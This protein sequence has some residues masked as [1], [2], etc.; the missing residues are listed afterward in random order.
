MSMNRRP[1]AARTRRQGK[2]RLAGRNRWTRSLEMLERRELL[3][4]DTGVSTPWHNA[5]N[6]LDVN[7]DN[8]VTPL[9]ALIVFNDLLR[10]GMRPVPLD[11]VAPLTNGGGAAAPVKYVDVTGDNIVTPLDALRIVNALAVDDQAQIKVVATDLF[12]TQITET[13]VGSQFQLRAI[14]Q[15]VRTPPAQFGGVFAAYLNVSYDSSLATIPTVG[16]QFEFDPFFSAVQT[17]DTGTPGLISGAGASSTSG[18]PPGTAPQPLWS[19]LVTASAAGV[20][21]FTP[22]FDSTLGHGV[23]LYSLDEDVPSNAIDFVGTT[24]TITAE[25]SI[26][27][28]NVTL[29]EGNSGTTPFVFNVSLSNVHNQPVTVQYATANPP[30]GNI[31]TPG[32]D[33]TATSG[34]LTFAPGT[35]LRAVTVLVNGDLAV[36]SDEVF[37]LVLSNPTNATLGTASTGIGTILN[38]DALSNLTIGDVTVQNVTAGTTNAVFTVTLSPAAASTATVQFATANGTA[39]AGVDYTST[40]GTLTFA[41]GVTTRTITVPVIG[42]PL[43]DTTETFFINLT[44]PSANALITDSQAQGTIL[45]AVAI[46]NLAIS[47]AA[48]NEGNVGTTDMVFTVSLSTPA[49]EQILVAYATADGTATVADDDYVATSGTLTFAPGESV[50]LIT[51]P[52]IGDTTLE[53]TETFTVNLTPVSGTLGTFQSQAT[54]TIN[55]DDGTPT[56]VIDNATVTGSPTSIVDAVFTVTLSVAITSQVTVSYATADGSAEANVDYLPQSG[57][58]TFTPG[59]SLTQTITVPVLPS[60]VAQADET[61]FVNLSSATGGAEI[62]DAQA[63][64]TIVRQG[65]T[66][67]D[68]S[69]LEGNSGTTDAVFTI[70]LTQAQQEVVTVQYSTA[71]GTATVAGADYVPTSGTV[72]FAPG[73]TAKTVTVAIVGDTTVEPN[74]TF[75]VN[76]SNAIG[77]AIFKETGIGTILNDDGQKALIELRLADASGVEFSGGETLDVNDDFRLH[78]YVQDIQAEPNGIAAAY[79]DVLYDSNLVL[80]TG[81]IIYGSTFSDVQSGSTATPGLIDEVGAFQSSPPANPGEAQLLFSITLRAIDVGVANFT[82]DPADLAGHDVLEFTSDLP[83]P[84]AAVNFVN[85]SINIGANV[86]TVDSVAQVEGNSG[87][88]DF[89][90]TVTRFLSNGQTATVVYSTSDGTATAGLDYL[91]TSGALTFLPGDTSKSVTVAVIG[92]T[93]DEDDEAFFVSLS[94]AVGAVATESPGVGTILNDDSPSGMAIADAVGNE[95]E[96]LLFTVSL[97]QVSGKT[98]TVAYTTADAPSGNLATPG[99]DYTPVAGTLTF[100]PGVTQQTITVPLLGDLIVDDN[101][102]FLVVLSDPTNTTLTGATATGTILDVPPAAISGFVY[103]D[104]NNNGLKEGSEVGIQGV[105]IQAIRDGVIVQTTI[106]AADGS[107]SLVGLQPG[108]YTIREVHPG[109]FLDG[110]DTLFGIDSAHNDQFVDVVLNPSGNASG[111]LFGEG[112]LR[113]EFVTAFLNR[114]AFLSSSINNPPNGAIYTPNNID[115]TRGDAWV[116]IDGGWQGTRT[117]QA[118]F[119]AS[120]GSATMYLYNNA[121]QL[122]AVSSATPTGSQM[123]Y[124]G[125]PG[126]AYFLKLSGTNQDVSLQ[127]VD[128]MS[129]NNVTQFEGDSGTTNMV[130]TAMLSAAQSQAVTVAYNTVDGTATAAS[131]D[132]VATSGTLTFMPGEVSKLITVLVNGDTTDEPDETFSLQLSAATNI[133]VGVSAGVGTILND[134]ATSLGGLFFFGSG[135]PL[136]TPAA[137]PAETPP[138]DGDPQE[139]EAT[140]EVQPLASA[141]AIA[142]DSS[143]DGET[144][145]TDA[146]LEDDEDWVTELMLA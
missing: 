104:A 4:A 62:G 61:F 86:F 83:I 21:S 144:S 9:D 65:L 11:E 5:N 36:E 120:Q 91:A 130:F 3:A 107:Y 139:P 126:P 2:R 138:S 129:I 49:G 28:N 82:A 80:V 102:V 31:A 103:V 76:L 44:N 81:P 97:S 145:A 35:T 119:D 37:H 127:I 117:L 146:A 111:Y 74:E 114:R 10:Y 84:S 45:P 101:E 57:I 105:T 143:S 121:M 90:F 96:D 30:S 51:V 55:N 46:P 99:L 53:D 6:P 93:I 7:G 85:D 40:S 128:T 38:D 132:Y 78:V 54:G 70:A 59:G 123:T 137:E 25:P 77:T 33:Y 52:I 26:T 89:V 116:S 17:F 14:V 13:P 24:L 106:T 60:A 94:D 39:L 95:G 1:N 133:Q 8:R 18:S 140:P 68:V 63:L 110:R 20:V 66:I 41:A 136:V 22:S 72:T 115:L 56:I 79:L 98:I 29:N 142:E 19:V 112:T 15:D 134:D 43:P 48:V 16:A 100:A 64:G 118:L 125:V 47:N 69:V 73:E 124:L 87:T 34:T 67:A 71:D 122:V 50:K 108:T 113:H 12:G 42:D 92:D 75:S 27:V 58:V 141:P 131:G 88:T 135:G 109:F 23:L 32:V